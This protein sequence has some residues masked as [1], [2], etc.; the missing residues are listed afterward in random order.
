MTWLGT[1][2]LNSM[3]PRR[4]SRLSP[5]VSKQ[6]DWMSESDCTNKRLKFGNLVT[7]PAAMGRSVVAA[8][9]ANAGAAATRARTKDTRRMR[10]VAS[11]VEQSFGGMV[12]RAGEP[13]NEKH[14]PPAAREPLNGRRPGVV[15]CRPVE[16]AQ[17][18][19]QG[20]PAGH[21]A[22][23]VPPRSLEFGLASLDGYGVALTPSSYSPLVPPEAE[24]A[25]KKLPPVA[26]V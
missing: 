10:M 5:V 20:R 13:T 4:N 17:R 7:V 16:V 24:T 18:H 1:G 9:P 11:V 25:T 22:R 8:V 2:S 15:H 23:M 14:L 12:G 21:R 3:N 6:V 26:A 19:D